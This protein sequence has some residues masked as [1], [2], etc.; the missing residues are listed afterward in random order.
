MTRPWNFGEASGRL[1]RCAKRLD[2]HWNHAKSAWNDGVS[3]EFEESL[4]AHCAPEIRWAVGAI[5]ELAD[6]FEHARRDCR[7]RDESCGD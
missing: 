7:D 6:T 5:R 1:E 4:I 3:R 2:D